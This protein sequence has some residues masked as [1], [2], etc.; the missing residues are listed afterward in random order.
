MPPQSA[1]RT[2]RH[3]SSYLAPASNKACINGGSLQ[4]SSQAGGQWVFTKV[5]DTAS[6][7]YI[8]WTVRCSGASCFQWPCVSGRC[9]QRLR[10]RI[11]TRQAGCWILPTLHTRLLPLL[12]SSVST[13]SGKWWNRWRQRGLKS[14]AAS[15]AAASNQT[16]NLAA[17]SAAASSSGAQATTAAAATVAGAQGSAASTAGWGWQ[18]SRWQPQHNSETDCK[19]YLGVSRSSC[20][21][22]APQMYAGPFGQAALV[23]EVLP[24]GTT[25]PA[26]VQIASVSMASGSSTIVNVL[27]R[28]ASATGEH[29]MPAGRLAYQHSG[30]CGVVNDANAVGRLLGRRQ[31]R[32]VLL[33]CASLTASAVPAI[34]SALQAS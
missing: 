25:L 31:R 26:A 28:K 1:N 18:P 15:T 32:A 5:P 34:A 14:T 11:Q 12:Q 8:T 3:C 21:E 27:L 13:N 17:T 10:L 4:L 33:A 22:E 2:R 30:C 24:V 16:A 9:R 6:H 20:R 23:W 29:G 7:Y 19:R